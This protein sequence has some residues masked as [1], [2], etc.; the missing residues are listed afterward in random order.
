MAKLYQAP[1]NQNWL[2]ERDDDEQP[3]LATGL[4]WRG[5]P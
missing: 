4:D 3:L 2:T 5:P 1:Q